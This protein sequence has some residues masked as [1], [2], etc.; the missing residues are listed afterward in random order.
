LSHGVGAG[1]AL[2]TTCSALGVG[3]LGL[4]NPIE[5]DA[6]GVGNGMPSGVTAWPSIEC[7]IPQIAIDKIVKNQMRVQTNGVGP[8][9]FMMKRLRIAADQSGLRFF[10][11]YKIVTK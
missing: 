4:T 10:E 2:T 3:S 9:I 5:T 8:N 6:G 11:Y 7:A 1:V